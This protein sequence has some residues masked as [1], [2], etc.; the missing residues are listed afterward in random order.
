MFTRIRRRGLRRWDV[1]VLVVLLAAAIGLLAPALQASREA[2]R[3]ATCIDN[4]RQIAN[5]LHNFHDAQRHFPTNGTVVGGTPTTPGTV[6][7]WS[8]LAELLSMQCFESTPHGMRLR[9]L[10]KT[11]DP[12]ASAA[13]P[14]VQAASDGYLGLFQLVCPSNPNEHFGDPDGGTGHKYAL[15]NYKGMGA[16]CMPSLMMALTPGATTV[17]AGAPGDDPAKHPDGVIFPG[18]PVKLSDITDGPQYTIMCVENIDNVG[19]AG[20][21]TGSQWLCA[22]DTVLV[23]LPVTGTGAVTFVVVPETVSLEAV[24]RGQMPIGSY[25]RTYWAPTGSMDASLG[26]PVYSPMNTNATYKAF[27]TYLSFNFA[28][29]PDKGTYPALPY[30]VPNKPAFGPSSGHPIIVNHLMADGSVR[31]I[32]RDVDVAL[33]MF[34][35][36]RAGADPSPY[37]IPLRRLTLRDATGRTEN[38]TSL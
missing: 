25:H 34:L 31:S 37:A 28:I 36:T 8:F 4:L 13:D 10:I 5:G 29:D 24:T 30:P 7:G 12:V 17:A 14:A 35:I 1:L 20:S 27:R 11:S 16:T 19:N 26:Y 32:D 6:K 9:E 3:R 33:Y 38:L 2:A 15:T 18:N 23:G 22:T 21:V